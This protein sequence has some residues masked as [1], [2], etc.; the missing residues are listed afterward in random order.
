MQLSTMCVDLQQDFVPHGSLYSPLP[1]KHTLPLHPNNYL[2]VTAACPKGRQGHAAP[3]SLRNQ[4]EWEEDSA[5]R[6]ELWGWD[7]EEAII[8]SSCHGCGVGS[9][10]GRSKVG[11]R[12]A[13]VGGAAC[14]RMQ[15]VVSG[16]EGE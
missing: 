6:M 12:L 15:S 14:C 4:K 7:W 2:S 8:G 16:F 1:P 5:V 11:D 3:G 9:G 13:G 10:A